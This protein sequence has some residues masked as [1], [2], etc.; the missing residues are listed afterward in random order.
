MDTQT[1][2]IER[3]EDVAIITLNRPDRGNALNEELGEQL[4]AT[5][6]ELS[7]DAS[8]RVLVITGAGRS[9]CTGGDIRTDKGG[10]K[11]VEG[12]PVEFY[13]GYRMI[14]EIICGL[15]NL[16]IPI[17]A[18]VNGDAIGFGAGVALACDI[19]IGSE[20]ARFNEAWVKLGFMPAAGSTWF[21]PRLIGMGRAAELIFTDRF[22]AAEEAEKLGVLNKLLPAS[23]LR[24]E[25]MKLAKG[26][27][28]FPPLAIK[29]AKLNLYRGLEVDLATALELAGS[30]Q[31]ILAS[32]EDKDEALIAFREKRQ[33]I[34]KGK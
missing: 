7:R 16:S 27:A 20:K 18:M 30:C 29:L 10:L 2:I 26:I 1:V 33:G 17:I 32:T 19:R 24:E 31:A 13:K 9:F 11:L 5:I 12:S 34:Y 25:T 15:Q 14:K 21:L 6:K 22:L 23:K 28:S 8:I 4:L 3:E